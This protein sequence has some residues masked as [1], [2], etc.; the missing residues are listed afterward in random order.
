MKKEKIIFLVFSFIIGMMIAVQ[1][2]SVDDLTGGVASS[3]KSRQLQ[4]ELKS[5]REKKLGLE[6]ELQ[7]LETK[8]KELKK[9]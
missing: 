3:Q 5:L 6:V 8:A 1:L 2:K 7:T 9:Q 4:S